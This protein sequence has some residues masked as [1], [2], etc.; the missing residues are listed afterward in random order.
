MSLNSAE[1][2][3]REGGVVAGDIAPKPPGLP[4]P[5]LGVTMVCG[6]L[7]QGG[8]VVVGGEEVAQ[9]VLLRH[10]RINHRV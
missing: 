6:R 7:V 9:A 8:I 10:S 1:R 2:P 5:V 3:V 4:L